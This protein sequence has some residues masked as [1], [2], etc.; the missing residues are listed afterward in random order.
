M[1]RT[2]GLDINSLWVNPVLLLSLSRSGDDGNEAGDLES[3]HLGDI[4]AKV[5]RLE[6]LNTL[7]V[8]SCQ[9]FLARVMWAARQPVFGLECEIISPPKW[10]LKVVEELEMKLKRWTLLKR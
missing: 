3:Q 2:L 5:E 7:K 1:R 10:V 8:N 4:E 9:A 6:S